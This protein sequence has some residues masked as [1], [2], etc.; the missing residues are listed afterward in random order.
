MELYTTSTSPFGLMA[1]IVILEKDLAE[2]VQTIEAQTRTV[3][4]PYY[5]I[6][7]S[8]RVPY[9]ICDDGTGFEETQL[10]CAYLDHLVGQPSLGHPSGRDGWESR[11]LEALARSM[12]DGV[13]VWSR[14]LTRVPHEQSPT[15]IAHETE[16]AR[17]MAETWEQEIMHPMMN[18]P[19]NMAQLTLAVTL[20]VEHLIDGFEIR[21]KCPNLSSW[22]T[23]VAQRP[24]FQQ[25]LPD[26]EI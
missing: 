18:G 1:R 13:S 2:R 4:S 11:R 6:N 5:E 15:I 16:R 12:L 22:T 7:P 17:R 21:G 3:G 26:L 10:I 24:S 19:L 23:R 8:G 25:L 9:L 14:E 20:N